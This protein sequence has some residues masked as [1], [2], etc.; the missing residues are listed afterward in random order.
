MSYMPLFSK[1]KSPENLISE[2]PRAFFYRCF[3]FTLQLQLSPALPADILL[4]IYTPLARI[5][6]TACAAAVEP[7]RRRYSCSLAEVLNKPAPPTRLQQVPE[8]GIPM[9]I[10]PPLQMQMVMA[11]LVLHDLIQLLRSMQFQHQGVE[12]QI[13][14]VEV[15]APACRLQAAVEAGAVAERFPEYADRD[16]FHQLLQFLFVHSFFPI[17]FAAASSGQPGLYSCRHCRPKRSRYRR[18]PRHRTDA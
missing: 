3:L 16:L 2:I 5:R 1:L 4:Q 17:I 15:V 7:F 11:E 9:L 18:P 8:V 12:I 6:L 14:A 13:M 10:P